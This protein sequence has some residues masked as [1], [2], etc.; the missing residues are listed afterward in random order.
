TDAAYCW[1]DDTP[2]HL[3]D[4]I[5][6]WPSPVSGSL[7]FSQITTG[8]VHTC[9]LTVNGRVYCW[10]WNS[11]GQLGIGSTGGSKPVP[12]PLSS[13]WGTHVF[14]AVSAGNDHTCAI[15]SQGFSTCWGSDNN[16]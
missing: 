3:G 11:S 1:G 5:S 6:T 14:T 10:G 15:S 4:N 12:T 8:G 13:P 9:G 2:E 7:A 16:G